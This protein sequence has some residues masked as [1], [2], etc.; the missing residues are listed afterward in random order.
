[1]SGH[2]GSEKI[3][4]KG[5]KITKIDKEN[6]L[7]EVKGSVPGANTNTVIVLKENYAR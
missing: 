1:M 2:M 5:L 7:I 4:Q 6:N 3:T